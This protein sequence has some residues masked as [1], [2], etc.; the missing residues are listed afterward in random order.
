MASKP[1]ASK[2]EMLLAA[3]VGA[4]HGIKGEVKL[5]LKLDNPDI[6]Q[7]KGVLFTKDRTPFFVSD[8]RETGKGLLV[9]FKNTP[10]RN[11]AEALRGTELYIE[12]SALP[13]LAED[14]FYYS[15]LAG[16]E[17]QTHEGKK[18]GRV[19]EVFY[20]GAQHVLVVLSPAGEAL[21]PFLDETVGE[22]SLKENV[23]HLKEG[24]QPFLE[25]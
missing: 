25:L 1:D 3:V 12:K 6:I 17:V 20:S 19:V 7:K 16:L 23:L 21:I 4:A 22:V 18:I 5:G 8:W 10:N 2:V 14:E 11:A 13:P 24:A 15:D 9:R